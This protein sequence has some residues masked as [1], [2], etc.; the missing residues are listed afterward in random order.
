VL[1]TASITWFY[2]NKKRD[3]FFLF[4][5]IFSL[6]TFQVFSPFQVSTSETLFPNLPPPASTRVFP[7]SPTPPIFLP[8]NFP[9]LEHW[10]PSGPRASP[11]TYVQQGHPLLHMQPVPWVPPCVFFGWWSNP[12]E[13]QGPVNI[14]APSLGL[15]TPSAPSVPSPTSPSGTSMLSSIVGYDLPPLYLSDS[16]RVS[17]ETAI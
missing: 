1:E 17:W 14:V 16:G 13:L 12:W 6:F 8:W 11:P 10:T 15:Q 7:H 4:Y 3:L 5:W 2:L 9:T